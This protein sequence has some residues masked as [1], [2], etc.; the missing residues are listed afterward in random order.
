[1]LTSYHTNKSHRKT[2]N[3]L[4]ARLATSLFRYLF[5]FFEV[6]F[7]PIKY[8]RLYEW[9]PFPK[10]VIENV[11][12]PKMQKEKRVL[13]FIPLSNFS[14][15]GVSWSASIFHLIVMVSVCQVM[16]TADDSS[17]MPAERICK[18]GPPL[19]AV[20]GKMNCL[21]IGDSVSMG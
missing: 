8:S 19:K 18:P 12:I 3:H 14:V 6:F 11:L 13:Q 20:T 17:V 15:I 4:V 9:I 16:S 21:I 1:M 10:E 7:T 5:D 2:N